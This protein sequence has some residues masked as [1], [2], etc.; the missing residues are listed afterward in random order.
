M[1]RIYLIAVLLIL[2]N[3]LVAK[4]S[5]NFAPL[6]L[7]KG[8]QN[9]EDFLPLTNYLKEKLGVETQF[10]RIKDYADIIKGF[11][12]GSI[13]MAYLGPLPLIYLRKNYPY[14]Q[15]IITFKQVNGECHY[16]CVLVK[17]KEDH[18]DKSKPIKI[19][20]TQPLST[21]GYYMTNILLKEKLGI[22]ISKQQ[23]SYTMSHSNALLRTLEGKF[24]IAG[25]K[26]TIAKQFATLGM[27]IIAQSQLL[28]GFTLVANSKTLS[29]EEI[30]A[31]QKIL[32]NIPKDIY[33]QWEGIASRGMIASSNEEY[34]SLEVDFYSI[35]HE[36]NM[37]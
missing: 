19:A 1:K 29:K 26:D 22:D 2:W 31:I 12:D 25:A 37:P 27:E 13:D 23:Y 30:D 4:D 21:C 28:P 36:G 17:F 3:H 6:P 16:R 24:T 9:I 15:P 33:E 5:I 35:P 14:T 10:V 11:Q 18:I 32:L 20:L 34:E 7:K 8:V